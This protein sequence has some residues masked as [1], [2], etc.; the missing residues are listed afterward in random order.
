LHA[1]PTRWAPR[2]LCRQP[3]AS[4]TSPSSAVVRPQTPC[5]ATRRRQQALAATAQRC[6][7]IPRCDNWRPGKQCV[8]P[9]MRVVNH[10]DK[11]TKAG[12]LY[13]PFAT[14]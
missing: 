14:P 9:D 6:N 4:S 12:T 3:R 2:P 11:T 10:A 1:C 7:R 8:Q 5:N 13:H